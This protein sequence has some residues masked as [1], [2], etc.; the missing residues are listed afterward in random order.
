MS[1]I[2][3]IQIRQTFARIGIDTDLGR[4]EIRQPRA[5]MD[6][7][8]IPPELRIRQPR[9]ELRIDQ[10]KAWDGLALGDHLRVLN[11]IYDH[12]GRV[13]LEAIGRIAERGDRMAAIHTGENAIAEIARD[14]LEPLPAL[15]IAGEASYDNVDITYVARKPDID[16]RLGKVETQFDARKPEIAYHRGKVRIYMRQYPSVVIIPPTIDETR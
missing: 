14:W 12:A 7:R 8:R 5:A 11:R 3:Q 15:P 10:S 2:P 4:Q 13:A 6:F 16:V 1:L 9:G